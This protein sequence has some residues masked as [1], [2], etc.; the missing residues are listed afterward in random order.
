MEA[1]VVVRGV[2]RFVLPSRSR[3][4]LDNAD[5]LL[6]PDPS[7]GWHADQR[8]IPVLELSTDA[9]SYVL[10]AAG[11]AGKTITFQALAD[12]E[13][14]ARYLDTAWQTLEVLDE[15]LIAAAQNG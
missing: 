8:P 6:V 11:G 7:E 2:R 12:I 4:L 13:P 5:F 14:A 9:P 1:N 15:E 10:L 3:P